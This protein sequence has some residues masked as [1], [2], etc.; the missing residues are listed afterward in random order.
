ME[1]LFGETDPKINAKNIIF[2]K[3]VT[4]YLC[5]FKGKVVKKLF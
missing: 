3:K 5:K 2:T 1:Y 4:K